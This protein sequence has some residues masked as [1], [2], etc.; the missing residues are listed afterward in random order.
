MNLYSL[1]PSNVSYSSLGDAIPWY[2]QAGYNNIVGAWSRTQGA[3]TKIGV[4][5]TGIDPGQD[6]F[7]S[8]FNAYPD[9]TLTRQENIETPDE[10]GHGTRVAAVIA[11]PQDGQNMMGIA[12]KS[13]LVVVKTGTDVNPYGRDVY[14]AIWF[15]HQNAAKVIEMAFK[16]DN[17]A[18]SCFGTPNPG[19]CSDDCYYQ[20]NSDGSTTKVC[21]GFSSVADEISYLYNQQ[22]GPLFVAAAG[23]FDPGLPNVFFPAELPEVIAVNGMNRD[24]SRQSSSNYG[25]K[26]EFA[27]YVQAMAAGAPSKGSAGIVELGGSSGGSAS[28]AGIA[29]LAWAAHPSWRNVDVRTRLRYAGQHPYDRNSDNGYGSIDAYFAA[30]GFEGLRIDGETC[31]TQWTMNTPVWLTAVPR[32]DGPFDYVWNTGET[33]QSIAVYPGQPGET[34]EFSVSV[35][36]RTENVTRVEYHDIYTLPADDPRISCS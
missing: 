36:D 19:G 27:G 33:T 13:D 11:A 12:W 31:E 34:V 16:T 26:I 5:D 3:H 8:R 18:P 25:S 2:Y 9:P 6:Q 30:G 22:D 1:D 29:L 17:Y 4:L 35:T 28:V 15:A 23:T 10:C 14:F 32:G 21:L 20:M 7:F 24:G